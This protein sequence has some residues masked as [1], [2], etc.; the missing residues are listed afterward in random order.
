MIPIV[1][2]LS[3]VSSY[4]PALDSM[5]PDPQMKDFAWYIIYLMISSDIYLIISSD[6][7]L[8]ISSDRMVSVMNRLFYLFS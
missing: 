2:Y 8:M 4:L 5:F 6:I 1:E 7:Y 3:V